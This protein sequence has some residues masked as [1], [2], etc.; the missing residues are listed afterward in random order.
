[1][2]SDEEELPRWRSVA[3]RP[4]SEWRG[5]PAGEALEGLA[6]SDGEGFSSFAELGRERGMLGQLQ[7]AKGPSIQMVMGS[8]KVRTVNGYCIVGGARAAR[9]GTKRWYCVVHPA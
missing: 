3:A 1:V 8:L 5:E 9:T 4:V 6:Y 2:L 7:L